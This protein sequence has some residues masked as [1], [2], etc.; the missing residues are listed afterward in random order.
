[1]LDILVHDGIVKHQGQSIL[2]GFL[3]FFP[4]FLMSFNNQLAQS[5]FSLHNSWRSSFADTTN[6]YTNLSDSKIKIPFSR[7][8]T[9]CTLFILLY[10][11]RKWK[12]HPSYYKWPFRP[13]DLLDFG[14][15]FITSL[16]CNTNVL[17]RKSPL[18]ITLMSFCAR[19]IGSFL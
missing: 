11:K 16:L 10:L 9:C 17:S 4:T 15:D 7:H 13:V 5:T 6:G 1:M 8:S 19:L 14:T 2:F 12:C 3:L 18:S